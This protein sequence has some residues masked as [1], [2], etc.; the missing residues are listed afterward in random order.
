M[1]MLQAV[2]LCAVSSPS[3]H[4]YLHPVQPLPQVDQATSRPSPEA[5]SRKPLGIP[6]TLLK[7]TLAGVLAS[8]ASKGLTGMLTP[9]DATF[10]KKR[11][12]RGIL[13]RHA[14][15][16][17]GGSPEAQTKLHDHF[18]TKGIWLTECSGG[19]WQKGDLLVA[20]ADLII[21]TTRNWGQSVVLWNLALDQNHAPHLG[22]CTDCRGVV[23]IDHSKSPATVTPTVDF[24]A[25]AHTSNFVAPGALR[26]DS[27]SSE[28]SPL[29]H[30]AFRNS[31]GSIVLLA[32]NPSE[33]AIT[34]SIAWQSQYTAYTLQPGAVVT[35]Y[36]P[37]KSRTRH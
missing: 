20:Q 1:L 34:F 26:I 4:P 28:E 7:S 32:L 8:V 31:D 14:T 2:R 23:T 9:L 12:G 35:F 22:G 13:S 17:Y 18:P 6:L 16:C 11:G 29:K 37:P 25:L 21:E 33:S 24:T 36:W 5:V 19:E 10:T 27:T 3:S 15:H 30:V